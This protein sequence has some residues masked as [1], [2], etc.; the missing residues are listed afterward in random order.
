[1]KFKRKHNINVGDKFL[2]TD[3]YL[4]EKKEILI[5][6]KVNTEMVWFKGSKSGQE[7]CS[8]GPFINSCT[9]VCRECEIDCLASA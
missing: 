3:H 5:I 1:M 8:S 6:T 4:W 7:G 2:I 9:K